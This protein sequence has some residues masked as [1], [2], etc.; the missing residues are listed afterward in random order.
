MSTIY[1]THDLA[2]VTQVAYRILVLR[3]GR[4]VECAPTREMLADPKGLL[5]PGD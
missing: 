3:Y 1:V 5:G 4:V 2:L